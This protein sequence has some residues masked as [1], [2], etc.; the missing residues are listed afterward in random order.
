MRSHAVHESEG[1][2]GFSVHLQSYL[3]L[4]LPSFGLV[5]HSSGFRIIEC[6]RFKARKEQMDD[7]RGG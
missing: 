7:C 3:E 1:F 4:L 5:I 2:V 6:H